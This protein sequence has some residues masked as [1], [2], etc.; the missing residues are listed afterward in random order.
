MRKRCEPRLEIQNELIK[1]DRL[2]NIYSLAAIYASRGDKDK[3]YEYLRLV[4]QRQRMPL[5]MVKNYKSNP[6]FDCIR[7]EP[8]FQHFLQD[9]I[10]KYEAEHE[11]VRQWHST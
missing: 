6:L 3:A 2:Y 9:V 8:E 7:D 5:Y 10:A 4:N 1:L 11:R